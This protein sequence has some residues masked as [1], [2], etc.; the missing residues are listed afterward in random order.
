M[1]ALFI[2]RAEVNDPGDR[3]AFDRWYEQE[4]LPQAAAAFQAIRAWRGW[5]ELNPEIHIAFYEFPDLTAAQ[6]VLDSDTFKGAHRRLRPGV[7]DEGV[8]DARARPHPSTD[9]H[10]VN[11]TRRSALPS[12]RRPECP[13]QQRRSGDPNC[14][15]DG[16][17]CAAGGLAFG[18][19]CRRS[20]LR[21]D[22]RWDELNG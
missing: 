21:H 9:H 7:G 3:E 18:L 15:D 22:L 1:T 5:S 14:D 12:R 20:V 17:G 2:V 6:M 10:L 19:E 4:H 8:T 11:R 16:C 13:N